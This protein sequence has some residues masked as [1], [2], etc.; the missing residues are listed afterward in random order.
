LVGFVAAYYLPQ[1]DL[2]QDPLVVAGQVVGELVLAAGAGWRALPYTPNTLKLDEQPKS[3]K[4]GNRYQVR[5]SA[6]RPQPSPGVLAALGALDRRR[7]L[8]LLVEAGGARRLVGSR[9][10]F[11]QLLTG[12]EGQNPATRA[13]VDLRLEGETT[14]LAPY[15]DGLV[16]VLG[17]GALGAATGGAAPS[18]S[19]RVLDKKGRVMATVPAGH[20]VII[21][22]SFQVVLSFQ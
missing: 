6:Q 18:G 13:G 22:S 3:D 19:V 5:V 14:R 1:E 16:S 4:Q 17:G 15:Y 20:D 8:L 21:A 9:E 12:T 11:V 7:L 2:A 10:E